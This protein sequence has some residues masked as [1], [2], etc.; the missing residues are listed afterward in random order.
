M[1]FR[2]AA[3]LNC[4]KWYTVPLGRVRMISPVIVFCCMIEKSPGGAGGRAGGGGLP[5]GG[6]AGGGL[7]GRFQ[8]LSPAW[9][10]VMVAAVAASMPGAMAE[11]PAMLAARFPTRNELGIILVGSDISKWTTGSG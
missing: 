3:T 5:V 7:A 10:P 2:S 11:K 1:V 6:L 4:W 9:S 8:K